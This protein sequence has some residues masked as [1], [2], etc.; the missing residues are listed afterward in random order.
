MG[1]RNRVVWDG[2]VITEFGSVQIKEGICVTPLEEI[3]AT[4]EQML[5]VV[6]FERFDDPPTAPAPEGDA[7][8][9]NPPAPGGDLK[10]EDV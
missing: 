5:T 4:E 6:H 1:L 7:E 3:G 2:E 10:T 8:T 9:D